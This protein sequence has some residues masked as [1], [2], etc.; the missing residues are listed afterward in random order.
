MGLQEELNEMRIVL[1][2]VVEYVGPM[3]IA[4]VVLASKQ[5]AQK[6]PTPEAVM[7]A[8]PTQEPAKDPSP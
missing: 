6:P 5:R 1:A 8:A 4:A 3:Q 7:D 2:A